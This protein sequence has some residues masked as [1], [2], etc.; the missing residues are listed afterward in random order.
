MSVPAPPRQRAIEMQSRAKKAIARGMVVRGLAEHNQH[1]KEQRQRVQSKT[2]IMNLL[3]A[4]VALG[5]G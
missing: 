4:I 2:T 1:L 5:E 3:H